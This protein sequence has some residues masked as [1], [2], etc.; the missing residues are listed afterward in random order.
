MRRRS[1]RLKN[2]TALEAGCESCLRRG[3][4]RV[5]NTTVREAGCESCLRR[6]SLRVKNTTVREAGCENRGLENQRRIDKGRPSR[7]Q[8]ARKLIIILEFSAGRNMLRI[9]L[10]FCWTSAVL[11]AEWDCSATS[12]VFTLSN[13]CVVRSQVEVTGILS[14]TGV[15]NGSSLPQPREGAC[16]TR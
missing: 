2:T 8:R 4:L 5:K 9:F 12:G 10:L 16:P 6:G 7:F 3:S 15:V 14:L 11:A 1:L 13:D